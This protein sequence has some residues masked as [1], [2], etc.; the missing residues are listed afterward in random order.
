MGI[1]RIVNRRGSEDLGSREADKA[2]PKKQNRSLK[3]G[4]SKT[5]NITGTDR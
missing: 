3:S 4:G 5:K 2:V 1:I